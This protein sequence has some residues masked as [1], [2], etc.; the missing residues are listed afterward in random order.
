[1]LSCWA[2]QYSSN[3]NTILVQKSNNLYRLFLNTYIK[4]TL[5]SCCTSKKEIDVSYHYWRKMNETLRQERIKFFLKK[6]GYILWL[7]NDN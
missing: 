7:W 6:R 4:Y 5:I 3:F 2:F 1:M